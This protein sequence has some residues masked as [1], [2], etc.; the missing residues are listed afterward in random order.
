MAIPEGPF[1]GGGSYTYGDAITIRQ[2]HRVGI[3]SKE[4]NDGV[5]TSSRTISIP[6]EF[7]NLPR[8][9]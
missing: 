2:Q 8:F 7:Q 4:W 6:A 5:N 1:T 3:G 9:L